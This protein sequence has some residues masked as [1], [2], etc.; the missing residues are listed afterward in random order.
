MPRGGIEKLKYT[1]CE[2][3]FKLWF[4]EPVNLF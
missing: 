1:P 3:K 2:D 4:G